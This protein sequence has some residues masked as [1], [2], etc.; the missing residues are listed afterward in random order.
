MSFQGLHGKDLWAYLANNEE[1]YLSHDTPA[2]LVMAAG[3]VGVKKKVIWMAGARSLRATA[4]YLEEIAEERAAKESFRIVKMA[5]DTAT[6]RVAD[7]DVKLLSA[8]V[9]RLYEYIEELHNNNAMAS[10]KMML[11]AYNLAISLDPRAPRSFAEINSTPGR[12]ATSVANDAAALAF[13]NVPMAKRLVANEV[14][15]AITWDHMLDARSAR[16]RSR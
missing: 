11:G 5:H 7:V 2:D 12:V 15:G 14:R 1:A 9:Y 13:G 10:T 3:H 8:V 6:K 16:R 4:G